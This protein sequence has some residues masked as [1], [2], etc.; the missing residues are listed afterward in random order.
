MSHN[1]GGPAI[2]KDWK[3]LSVDVMNRFDNS[4]ALYDKK[5]VRRSE[6]SIVALNVNV[7]C[8]ATAAVETGASP[9]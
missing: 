7:L 5:S 8:H 2:G 9:C 6:M 4:T 1:A 3:G